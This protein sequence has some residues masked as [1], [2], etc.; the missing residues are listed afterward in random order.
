MTSNA[1]CI[2]N[3]IA[4]S[5]II[6]YTVTQPVTP[7]VAITAS[8]TT[9]CTGNNVTFTATPTNGG[10]PIYQWQRNGANIGTNSATFSSGT[11]T[12]GDIITCIMTSSVA[13][14]TSPTATSNGITITVSPTLPSSVSIATASTSICA[15]TPTT[16]TA[17]PT[18]GGPAPIYQW[19]QNGS[20]VGTNSP[21][22]T[23][24]TLANGHTVVCYMTSSA[25]CPSPTQ[26]PSNTI[27]MAVTAVTTPF[28]SVSTN[29]GSSICEG[30]NVIFSAG[31]LNGGSTPIYQWYLNGSPVGTNSSIYSNNSLVNGNT[32]SCTLTSNQACVTTPTANSSNVTMVVNTPVTPAVSITASATT[33]CSGAYVSY[34]ATPTNGGTPTYQ[35]FRDGLLV[36]T[37]V[38]YGMTALNDGEVVTCVMT[39][40]LSCVTSTTAA[41]NAITMTVNP[42]LIPSVVIA[43]NPGNTICAGTSVTFTAT[44]TN[45]GSTPVYQWYV[46]GSS[47]GTNSPTYTSTTLA[48]G[49]NIVCYMTSNAACPNPTQATSNTI[50]MAVTSNVTPFVNISTNPGST[51][52][53]GTNVIFTANPGNAGTPAYQWYL[54]GSPVGTNSSTYSNSSLAN[55]NTVSCILTSNLACVTS[56]TANSGN[57]IMTVNPVVTP[58]VSISASAT[59]VCAG[60]NVTYTATPTNG[61]TPTYQWFRNGLLVGTGSSF[62]TSTLTNSDVITCVM[63]S[64]L[65][66]VTA[67]TATS[68]A[69]TMTVNPNVTPSVNISAS[70]TTICAGTSVTFTATPTN[71]GTTPIYQWYV[72]GSSVGTNNS[73][74]TSTTLTNGSNIICYMTSNAACPSPTQVTS[75]TITMAVTSNVTPFV[76]ISTNPG[77]TICAGTNVIFTANPGNGGTPSYQWYL[78]GSPVGTNSNTYSNSSLANGNTVNCIMTSNQA[79]ITSATANSGNITMTVNATVTP[80]VSISASA[81]TICTGSNATFTATPTNG[82]T[83]TYQWFRNG[84]LVGTNSTTYSSTGLTN[85]DVI[86]CVMTSSLA[87]VTS[88]AVTSNAITMTVNQNAL[89][90]VNIT[91]NTGSTICAGTSV[92]FTATPTNGG[93]TPSY[94]WYV[95]GSSVGT[96][97]PTYT[98]ATLA[99]GSNIIC[100]M[101]SNAACPSPTTATSNTITMA[102]TT[103]VTPF[104]NISTNPGNTICAGTNVIFTA[105]PGNGGTPAYQWYL[106]GSPVGTNSNVYSNSSLANG[107]TVN[108]IL[109]SSLACVTSTTANSSNITM[110][111]GT[112]VTPAVSISASATTICTGTNVTFTATPV[113]GGTPVY[114]WYRNGL[115]V[116]TNNA[117]YS[118]TGLTN[119]DVITCVMTSSL[120]CVTATSVTSNA[121]TMTVNPNATPSVNISAN[122]GNSICSGTSVTFTATPTNG[123]ATPTY[124]WW[125]NGSNVG[126]NSPTY[127][128]TTLANGNNV[129]C[130][131]TSSAACPSPTTATSNMITMVVTTNVTPTAS[132]SLNPGTSICAGTNVIFTANHSNAGTPTYQ[133]YVN[134]SPVGTNN[135]IYSNNSLANGNTVNCVVTSSLA[136]VTTPTA[137]SN[138]VTMAVGTPVTPAVSISSTATTICTGTNVTFTA[139][140]TNGGTPTY[141][142]FRNGLLVG[143]NSATYNPSGLING[144]VIT[145]TM[146]SSLSCATATNVTSN[147]I[148][149]T[150]NLN[151]TPS[152]NIVSNAASTIC[153]GTSVTFTATPTNGGVTPTY[154]WQVNGSNVGT[155]SPTYTSTTLANNNNVTCNMISTAACPSPATATS[156][157]ITMAVTTNVTPSISVSTSTGTTICSGTNVV[158]TASTSNAG[159]PTYQWYLNG[160]PVGN[161]S[162][163]YSNGSLVSGN[164]VNCVLTSSLT[165]VTSPTATSTTATM[166]V[167][168]PVTPA[169]TISASATTICAGTNVTFTATPTNGG[170]PAYHW[171][172]NGISTGVTS[173][174]YNSSSLTSGDVITC[175]M[176]SSLSCVTSSTA[177]SNAVTMTVNPTIP[178][179]VSISSTATTICAGSSV[180]FTATP[181]NGGTPSYQWKLNGS[182]VGTNSPTYTSVSLANGNTITC[183]MISSL[184]CAAPATAT[185]NTITMVVTTNVTPTASVTAST[186]STTCAGTN[187]TFTAT[188]TN[189]GTPT[190]Q[191]YLNGAPVGT[192]SNTY[193]NNSLVTGNT[194][195]CV[196]TS[197]L[198]CV[199]SSTAT[200]NTVTMTVNT[201]VTPAVSISASATTICA[202]TNVTFTATPTNG[203]TPT[204]QWYRN[205]S[206]VGTNSA[207]YSSTVLTNGDIITC[208]LTSSLS[209]VTSS[210]ATSNAVTMTVN[211]TIA[212]SVAISNNTGTTICAGSSVTF[213]ATPTNGG[214]PAYQWKLNGS[215]VGANSPTYTN[216]SLTNGNTVSCQMI[217][218]LGC[219]AP[220]TATSNTITMTVTANVT[221]TASISAST[222][223]TICAGT[224]VTFTA[225]GTNLGGTPTYQW[226]LNG[227]PVGTNSNAY[228]NNALVT[229]NTVNCVITSSVTCVTTPSATSNT[230]TMTVNTPVTPAVSISASNTTI[231]SG[232]NV[233]FT[234]TPTNGGTPTYQWYRNGSP[235]G[236][237]SATY[238]STTFA[239]GDVI[240]CTMTS[241]LSCVTTSTASSNSVGMTVS[242]SFPASVSIASNP[243]STICTGTSVTFTAT[244]TNGGTPSY[245][246]FLNGSPVGTNSTTYTNGTLSNGNVVS[247]QMTSSLGCA[248]PAVSSN[249]VTMTVNAIVTP[250]VT[251]SPNTGTTACGAATV[252]F[253]ATPTNGGGSPSY[254]W[255]LNGA[256]V[257]TNSSTYSNSTLVSG[258]TVYCVMTSSLMCLTTPSGTSNTVTMTITTPATPDVT[259]SASATTICAGSSV[260]FTA[261]PTNG[262]TPSYQWYRNGS[263]VGTNS[264]TYTTSAATNGSTIYCV[265]TSSLGCVTSSTAS[266]NTITMTV[267]SLVSNSVSISSSTGSTNCTGE[268]VTFTAT[269]TNGGATPD[270]IWY[271]NGTPVWSGSP[272]V[273]SSLITGDVVICEMQSSIACPSPSTAISNNI[274]MTTYS[275]SAPTASIT[276]NSGSNICTGENVT[277][278]ATGINI[279]TSPSYQ[280]YLN[281]SPVGT[282]SATYSTSALVDGSTVNCVVTSNAP[283]VSGQTAT[284]NIITINVL[285][286]VT[287]AVTISASATT[288]CTGTSVTFT[289][290]PTNGGGSPDYQWYRNGSPVGTNSSTYTSTTLTNGMAVTCVLTSSASCVTVSTATSNS[291]TMTVSSSY[292]ASVSISANTGSTICAG[293]SVTFTATPTNGGTPGYQWKLN[294]SNVGTNS[295]VYTNASLTDGDVV[296]CQMTS[297]LTC[298]TPATS[299]SNSITMTVNSTNAPTASITSDQGPGICAGGTVNFSAGG[300]NIG[301]SPDYQ[302]FLNGSPVG[303]NSASYSASNP[304]NGSTVYCVITSNASCVSEQTASSNTISINIVAPV[305]PVVSISSSA[306]SICDGTSVTFTATP[307]NGGGSPDYQWYRNGSPVGGNSSSYSSSTLNNGDVVTC[308]LTSSLSCVTG[309]TAN[310][311]SITITVNPTVLTSVSITNSAG[312]TVCFGQS[313]TFTATPTNG[314]TPSYQW[315]VNGSPVGTNSP[316]YIT[317]GLTNGST[318]SCAMTSSLSCPSP[319]IANS[320]VIT[321]TVNTNVTPTVSI[322]ANPGSS[323]CGGTNVTFTASATNEG[324]SPTYQ[325]FLNGSPVGTNSTTYSNSSLVNGNT[326]NCVVTSS[327]PCVTGPTASSNT[328]T[329]N[330][331][332]PVA[333]SISITASATT[334]CPGASINFNATVSNGGVSPVYQWKVNGTNVGTNSSTYSS[335]S[336]N[337]GDVVICVLTSSISCVTNASVNSNGIT[338]TVNPTTISA[339]S[340]SSTGSTICSGTSVTFTATPTNGGTPMYQWF[341]N[342]SPVGTNSSTYTSSSLNNNDVVSCEMVS[343]LPCNAPTVATSNVISMTVNSTVAPTVSIVSNQGSTICAGSTVTF[344]ATPTNGGGTPS[345]QWLLNGSPVGTNASVYSN[346]SLVNGDVVNCILTSSATCPSTTTATSNSVTINV[347][348]P[349][350]PVVSISSSATTI[351]AGTNVTFTATSTNG[352]GTPT[353]QWFVNGSPVGTNSATYVTSALNNGEVVTCQLTSSITC[354]TTASATSNSISMTVNPSVSTS[355]SISN[356]TGS[357]ICSGTSVTFTAT[358]TNGGTP[359]YQWFVNGSP[360]GTNSATY[361]TSTLNNGEVV[362]CQMTS[363]LTC[364]APAIANS[365]AITMTVNSTTAPTISITSNEGSS[366]CA[367]TSVTFTA[368]ATN[369]GAT[370]V[371]QWMLNGSPVGTNSSTYSNGLL[372]NGDVVT[373]VLTSS[374][375]CPA[376][377]TAASNAITFTVNSIITTSVS[378]ATASTTICSG[379]SVTFTATPTNGGTPTYQ[380]FVGSTPVGTNSATYTTSALTNGQVVSCQMSSSLVCATPA[381]A[382]SNTITMT[383]NSSATPT[384][385][386]TSNPSA[387]TICSGTSVTFTANI[388]NGGSSPVYQ[389]KLNGSNVGTNSSTYSNSTLTTGDA[390]T[391]ELTSNAPC[392][393]TTTVTSN[394]ISKTVTPSVTPTITIV[395][396]PGMPVCDE[397]NITFTATITN[398]G[399]NPS[400]QWKKNGLNTGT[401]T[402]SHNPFSPADGDIFTCVLTSNATCATSAQATSN[403]ITIDITTINAT[404]TVNDNT[405]T[406]T[407]SGATYQWYSCSTQEPIQGATQQS[408]EV[409]ESG[410]YFVEITV[411]SCT[412]ESNCEF[413]NWSKIDEFTSAGIVLYPNPAKDYFIIDLPENISTDMILYDIAGRKVLEG[414]LE[415][416]QQIDVHSLAT[417]S[418]RIVLNDGSR[419]YVGK[420]I[421]NR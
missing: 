169:V 160:T 295:A 281:G 55:G 165:C 140:P 320:N 184:G 132:I 66:C 68:N 33:V 59:T 161:N 90:S 394:S 64:S 166:T 265:M 204:Y 88:T 47:V 83:P 254:Q 101:T 404:V 240:T 376:T 99:N 249:S 114:Q 175:F 389:W 340:I 35:W 246:W 57:Y 408:F 137:T 311:N 11:L 91:A 369:G 30:T 326:I 63:T 264:S 413:V 237:N 107:N 256:P 70:S 352:G 373:C 144:D 38:S 9:I 197:S 411:G 321:M 95:N 318:V 32:V 338:I 102:V 58:A 309:S 219:A 234:A 103:N 196:I 186:G 312:S 8:A 315:Y 367:G 110:S 211:A 202:G 310:S 20:S 233:T 218:S 275:S 44:P 262:G 34:T 190:Y 93:S 216:A 176:T 75:N 74:Y 379:T 106:N 125:V 181:T 131:M 170:S 155:N 96:N 317:S 121:I 304:S 250:A 386:I 193:S 13:C 314:G 332:T 290:T 168:T 174:T 210:T 3:A 330:V 31:S 43:A 179:S 105:N 2:S 269:P 206:P 271:V 243:G 145:C 232:T 16:F 366:I 266:S 36:G 139:T 14:V 194:V 192:N 239:Q 213:T 167:N 381:I 342:S 178:S 130:Y 227:S 308:M 287:P 316:T 52:C 257:G 220:A 61:G 69:I 224:N 327:T 361:V 87:C 156:N 119:S 81:T 180:T 7:A 412:D 331:T 228:S 183:Q 76:N 392:I 414:K 343:S 385:S 260:T 365:N 245:Q 251:V 49:S 363:S 390:V 164:T 182:N 112:P 135:Y 324:S 351:C 146:T 42:N 205:G 189:L 113:N 142:W 368:S 364:A 12:N 98:S 283:C 299:T 67:T 325:W 276:S 248:S 177:A 72:N 212:T 301:G 280:W 24:T 56:T 136:C 10:T 259:I 277:F 247:C 89:A 353:Y 335:S 82:G 401:N 274:T 172:K 147:A 5:S 417:G 28:V 300:T 117:V 282:N 222:G 267:N 396:N 292:A 41:S 173:A 80:A 261:T 4:P 1:A 209:C 270:Y 85:S 39:S 393:S 399:A 92:T 100:Y 241:S 252:T 418:Y 84:L 268:V 334:I 18:N 236:T 153:A 71:G 171:Y 201:P 258:N 284:T 86:T 329:M 303:I 238:S 200:S 403:P 348:T 377:T 288:I 356:S 360:V 339:V 122:T 217:S 148:T 6:T 223:S 21:T 272:Y 154:Q 336:L 198:T 54:N 289:A 291:I 79:C 37:G 116:G 230:I 370:P 400:Y 395:S 371:Y 410:L 319:A 127:T 235:V 298:A 40:S 302:W 383:V 359:T 355:V 215:N 407:Q 188:G 416:N 19:Y 152:V 158:F 333:P 163:T 273:T 354:V 387:A 398:G 141:Q 341:V 109:T 225:S 263:P 48:N 406:A 191:W 382:A 346:S 159:T 421:V 126:T 17:T 26:T 29:P 123:G 129:I 157:T 134:G 345:Y 23:T 151:A 255:Y 231:C 419:Q 50:A 380:W 65:T 111:V 305:T 350:T 97:S 51:I 185:S 286:T 296:T 78:N 244:P 307:T 337:N 285:P 306:T 294:G 344:T 384:I 27:T 187:V 378:I 405:I 253:T 229:G 143:T 15:G 207:T 420:V 77:N 199:T 138:T 195:N 297:S 242:S 328:I 278:T 128:T 150:V 391:C 53:A 203:G 226:Y 279:G 372:A 162:Y 349:V 323:I 104:V 374:A 46:N 94:Q 108:C 25:A 120:S 133:W 62:N 208:T 293:N 149:M 221:P 73:T 322:T 313:V 115:P 375:I 415:D 397:T 362:T 388:S 402:V 118:S 124:Q 409:T 22:Y 347:T 357:T 358:A 60:T 45:G 214:T